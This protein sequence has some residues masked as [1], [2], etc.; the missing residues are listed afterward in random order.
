[1]YPMYLY[2]LKNGDK[3]Q[4]PYTRYG[5][6]RDSTK[7]Y[8]PRSNTFIDYK[9]RSVKLYR[10]TESQILQKKVQVSFSEFKSKVFT[11]TAVIKNGSYYTIFRLKNNYEYISP[12]KSIISTTFNLKNIVNFMKN[13]E[14]VEEIHDT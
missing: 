4:S 2:I 9:G 1:M 8:S 7:V 14:V 12:C 10:M 3:A 13:L 5:F 6:N 11:V